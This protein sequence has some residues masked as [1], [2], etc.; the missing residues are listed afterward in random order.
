MEVEEDAPARKNIP[1]GFCVMFAGNIGA[2]QDF[3][4]ILSAA[5]QLKEYD[6]IHWVIVGDGRMRPWVEAQIEERGLT[7]TFHLLGR[8]PVELM[9]RFFLLQRSC[10]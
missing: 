10:W 2:T 8:H 3:E 6:D 9:P 5:E 1:A 7:E 4:T